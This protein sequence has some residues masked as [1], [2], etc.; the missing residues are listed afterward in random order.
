MDKNFVVYIMEYYSALRKRWELA[1]CYNLDGTRMYH[2][3]W[4]MSEREEKMP[5]DLSYLCLWRNKIRELIS[6]NNLILDHKTN[7]QEVG[8]RSGERRKSKHT[9]SDIRI[10]VKGLGQF[11]SGECTLIL[12]IKN[13]KVNTISTIFSKLQWI[14]QT[15]T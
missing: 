12:Y 2:V 4:S 14:F 11:E 1:I 10:V 6:N 8:G 15:K 9:R 3:K 7:Y 13:F 5:V